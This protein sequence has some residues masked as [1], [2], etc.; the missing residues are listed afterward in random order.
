MFVIDCAARWGDND[1]Y[2]GLK[3]NLVDQYFAQAS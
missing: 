3:R 2:F 1:H